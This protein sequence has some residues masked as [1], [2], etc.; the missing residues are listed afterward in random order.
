MAFFFE[1]LQYRFKYKSKHLFDCLF[2]CLFLQMV[3]LQKHNGILLSS[4]D[5]AKWTLAN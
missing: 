1:F 3:K 2:V 5:G 4:S